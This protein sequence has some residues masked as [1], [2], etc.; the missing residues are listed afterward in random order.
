L[1]PAQFPGTSEPVAAHDLIGINSTET[2]TRS[3]PYAPLGSG[4]AALSK[5]YHRAGH[6]VAPT[7]AISVGSRR[8]L[9]L[10]CG[11]AVR[12]S[13]IPPGHAGIAGTGQDASAPHRAA[14]DC[15]CTGG[16]LSSDSLVGSSRDWQKRDGGGFDRRSRMAGAMCGSRHQNWHYRSNMGSHR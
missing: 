14:A 6:A 11:P 3:D 13:D 1:R 8:A 7:T 5:S 16:D 9:S 12:R 15:H 10:G 4:T 2:S